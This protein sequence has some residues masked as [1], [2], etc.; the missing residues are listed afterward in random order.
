[1]KLNMKMLNLVTLIAITINL[2][3]FLLHHIV[4]WFIFLM[5]KGYI[6]YLWICLLFMQMCIGVYPIIIVV[7]FVHF[8]L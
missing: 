1:M 6:L 4:L 3:I 7:I 2:F 8:I 5:V